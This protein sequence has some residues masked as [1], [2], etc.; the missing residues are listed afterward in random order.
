MNGAENVAVSTTRAAK[1]VIL[2]NANSFEYSLRLL[3]EN[4]REIAFP[5]P[6]YSECDCMSAKILEFS[7]KKT[8]KYVF[9]I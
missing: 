4:D 6:I 7:P 1:S 2:W 9:Q 8:L 5:F 3:Y